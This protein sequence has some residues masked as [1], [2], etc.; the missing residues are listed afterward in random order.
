MTTAELTALLGSG[1]MQDRMKAIAWAVEKDVDGAPDLIAVLRSPGASMTAHA[2]AMIGLGHL[3]PPAADL[4]RDALVAA[5]ADTSPTTRRGAIDTLRRLD[6]VASIDAI[7]RLLTDDTVDPSAW[8]DDDCTVAMTAR[9]AFDE[10][11]ASATRSGRCAV[12]VFVSTGRFRSFD[13]LR[14]YVDATYTPDGDG[15]PSAFMS[16]VDLHA[17][18][19][20]C[21]EA[22]A[23]A[24]GPIPVAELIAKCSWADQWLPGIDAARLADAAIC[25][26]APN[27]VPYPERCSLQ[28]LG[29]VHFKVA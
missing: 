1:D 25:V 8:T 24:S 17:Y 4:A 21:I 15:I 5:L 6:D 2:W 12:H 20:M 9:T 3:G 11:Q 26:F 23:S 14:A 10:L 19:P 13:E 7:A 16:E 18:E 29:V 28:H 22:M 27:C